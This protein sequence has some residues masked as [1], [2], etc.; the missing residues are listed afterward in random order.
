MD[1]DQI[2]GTKIFS[3]LEKHMP[4]NTGGVFV[5]IGSDRGEGSTR[6]LANLAKTHG[7]RLISVDIS[8]HAQRLHQHDP[9]DN[10]EFVIETG[11]A[12]AKSFAQTHTKIALLYL[13]NFDY[14]YDI[15]DADTHAITQRQIQD[16]A[17]RGIVMSN[18]HCQVEHMQQL[19]ALYGSFDQDTVIMFDDTYK[20]NDCWIGKCGPCVTYLL[21]QG[22]EVLEWTTDCGM[23][24]K[25]KH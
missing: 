8:D 23:I 17:R 4:V 21:C 12:W 10:V 1:E 3:L 19:L 5:E 18:E 16:Y 6:Y 20:F 25:K 24:M 7:T 15:K 14:M 9:I 11:S 2:M 13:D 22:Y